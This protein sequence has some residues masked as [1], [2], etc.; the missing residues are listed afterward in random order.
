MTIDKKVEEFRKEFGLTDSVLYQNAEPE[1]KVE[2]ADLVEHYEASL[3]EVEE[4]A[5]KEIGKQ[6]SVATKGAVE[7]SKDYRFSSL[8]SAIK[9]SPE[10]YETLKK[11]EDSMT[12][13]ILLEIKLK[14]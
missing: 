8:E 14:S 9:E 5:K 7:Y 12:Q 2:W 4:E 6:L 11:L 1:E 10:A 13:V 3:R